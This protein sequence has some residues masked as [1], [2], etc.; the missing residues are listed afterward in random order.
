MKLDKKH[1]WKVQHW[2]STIFKELTN[3]NKIIFLVTI[4]A[5]FHKRPGLA[6]IS[7]KVDYICIISIKLGGNWLFTGL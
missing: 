1:L 2:L 5:I 6:T 7:L 3:K 4:A